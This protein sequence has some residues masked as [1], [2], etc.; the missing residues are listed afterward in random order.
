M[1]GWG[2][3]Y[4]GR[5]PGAARNDTCVE[6]LHEEGRGAVGAGRVGPTGGKKRKVLGQMRKK[7]VFCTGLDI[8][9]NFSR[10]GGRDKSSKKK[11]RRQTTKR[12]SGEKENQEVEKTLHR[13]AFY[14]RFEGERPEQR[15]IDI[16]KGFL[17][18]KKKARKKGKRAA[19]G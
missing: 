6:F 14:D 13:E 5:F 18:R 2:A 10:G 9:P 17:K 4:K 3:D 11:R 8:L 19:L 15:T 16:R 1:P 12:C 7:G